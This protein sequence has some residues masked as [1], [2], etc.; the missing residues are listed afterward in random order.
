VRRLTGILVMA[1]LAMAAL[2][3]ATPAAPAE[4][5]TIPSKVKREFVKGCREGGGTRRQCT[6]AIN[7]LERHYSYKAFLDL[8]E[9]VDR[10]GRFTRKATKLIQRC[11]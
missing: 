10:H 11:A 4:G 8:I 3:P 7:S 9:F 6:C 1:V 2:A 5:Y